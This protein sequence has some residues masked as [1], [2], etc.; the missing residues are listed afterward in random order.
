MKGKYHLVIG[1]KKLVYELDIERQ[2]TVIKGNSATGKSTLVDMFSQIFNKKRTGLHCNM[3][4]KLLVLTG[5]S[6][7]KFLISVHKNKIFIADEDIEY[8]QT[9]E[10]ADFIRLN[11]NYFIFITR[12]QGF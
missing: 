7:W 6:D 11:D 12:L 4:D 10:F 8:I 3:T 5:S 1:N 9:K 2:I